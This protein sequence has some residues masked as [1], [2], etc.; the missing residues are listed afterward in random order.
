MLPLW[1]NIC[2][3][4]RKPLWF[5]AVTPQRTGAQRVML[6]NASVGGLGCLMPAVDK[7]ER[8]IL[9]FTCSRLRFTTVLWWYISLSENRKAC[10][11]HFSKQLI[12]NLFY[13]I[14]YFILFVW[15]SKGLC[16]FIRL[17]FGIVFWPLIPRSLTDHMH[18]HSGACYLW[19]WVLNHSV[20]Q[21][22]HLCNSGI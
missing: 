21:R 8:L 10:I 4:F 15:I 9:L 19:P 3:L 1:S 11:C 22:L 12:L 7:G 14:F 5:I 20:T 13:F 18:C 16:G 2:S 6:K 17:V